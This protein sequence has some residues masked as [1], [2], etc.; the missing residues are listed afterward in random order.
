MYTKEELEF[1]KNERSSSQISGCLVCEYG[2]SQCTCSDE[3][4]EEDFVLD[5]D[6]DGLSGCRN[7]GTDCIGEYC[8]SCEYQAMV[9][10]FS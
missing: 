1:L 7:C 8:N 3:S 5:D 4:E 10:K 2:H 6:F 9:D